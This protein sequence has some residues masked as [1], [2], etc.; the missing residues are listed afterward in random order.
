MRHL[1][2]EVVERARRWAKARNTLR[3]LMDSKS[4]KPEAVE[5]AKALYV[6]A[7]DELEQVARQVEALA[8]KGALRRKPQKP[9]DWGALANAAAVAAKVVEE[10][11][12][13][14]PRGGVDGVIDVEWEAVDND[15]KR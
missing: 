15:R 12:S 4:A 11:V 7:S 14:P 13:A 1:G 2:F 10:V 6:K 9:F 3:K 5:K 8:S